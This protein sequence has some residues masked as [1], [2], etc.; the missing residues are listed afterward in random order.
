MGQLA[1]M[2]WQRPLP[3]DDSIH[4]EDNHNRSVE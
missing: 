1:V 3:A 2:A 4:N